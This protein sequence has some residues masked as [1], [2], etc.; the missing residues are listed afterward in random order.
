M[1]MHNNPS[2][3]PEPSHA[4][5]SV[6][7]DLIRAGHLLKIELIDHVVVGHNQRCSLRELGHFA[8]QPPPLDGDFAVEG[9]IDWLVITF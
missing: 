7:R 4:D 3:E 2:G 5:I 8:H 6:T 1:L 9:G